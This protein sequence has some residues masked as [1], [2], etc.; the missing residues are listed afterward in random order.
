MPLVR[1]RPKLDPEATFM[2]KEA[3]REL[4]VVPRT[5][6]KY[7]NLGLISPINPCSG[8][9]KFTGEAIMLCWDKAILL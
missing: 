4:G 6:M 8:T 3:E 5:F 1:K 7:R 2:V 9:P